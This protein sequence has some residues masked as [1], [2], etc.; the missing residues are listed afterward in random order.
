M[1]FHSFTKALDNCIERLRNGTTV[2]QSL[3][4][5][6]D[7]QAEIAPLLCTVLELNDLPRELPSQEFRARSKTHLIWKLQHEEVVRHRVRTF[8]PVSLGDVA[9]NWA[10]NLLRTLQPLRRIAVPVTLALLLV[11]GANL[12][13]ARFITP[14]PA[15]AAQCTLSLLSGSAEVQS[16]DLGIWEIAGDGITLTAGTR[17]KTTAD[18]HAVLTF[19]EG[20]TVKLEPGTDIEIQ[21]MVKGADGS[22]TIVLKLWMGKTWSRVVKMMDPGSHYEIETPTAT[23][24]VRGTLFTTE[25]N[26][27]GETRVATTQGLVSVVGQGEE[28]YLPPNKETQVITNAAPLPPA[29]TAAPKASLRI[30]VDMPAIVS[31]IDPSGSSTGGF[32]DGESFNQIPG[33]NSLFTDDN[34]QSITI[35]HPASGEYV[36]ALRYADDGKARFNITGE[37]QNKTSFNYAGT[38][39]GTAGSGWLIRLNLDVEDGMIVESDITNIQPLVS[40]TPEKV[41]KIEPAT[42]DKASPARSEHSEPAKVKQNKGVTDNDNSTSSDGAQNQG[43]DNES[44]DDQSQDNGS[45]NKTNNGQGNGTENSADS[46]S[47]GNGN[48]DKTNNGQGNGNENSDDD[49]G[50]GND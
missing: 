43:N 2:D 18:S 44:S 8:E 41:V 48:E 39:E 30:R 42:E 16:K 15:L 35:P 4:R 49:Q 28:V 13:M 33:S 46:Q 47:Q 3:A 31:V 17:I 38:Y 29:E 10:D 26:D 25:V 40:E 12:G 20:S 11:A 34:N 1:I 32:A 22:D 45:E 37:S 50:N 6:P 7:F 9:G 23:A 24:I 19:F 21:Q 14:A 27:Q 5:Y 36:I